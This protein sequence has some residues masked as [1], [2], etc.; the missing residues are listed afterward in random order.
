MAGDWIPMRLDLYED[1]AV[2]FM[3]GELNVREEVVVGYLHRVWSWASRQCHAGRVTNVTLMS[4]GR[5]TNVT[6]FPELMRDAGWLT[7]GIDGDGRRF[8]EFPNWENWLGQSAKKR[9][10]DA[11]RQQKR[12]SPNAV[13]PVTQMSRSKRDKNVTTVQESTGE[14]NIDTPVVPKGTLK[15]PSS[16]KS[17]PYSE[18]FEEFWNAY[19][20]GGRTGKLATF[21][22]YQKSLQMAT[23]EQLLKG[24]EMYAGCKKV[25]EGF[26]RNSATWLNQGCWEDTSEKAGQSASRIATEDDLRN[27]TP[28]G[29]FE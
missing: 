21:K 29:M 15:K 14:K 9:I 26:V 10:L 4:L 18:Q 22:A 28:N 16:V 20:T 8:V 1:P 17:S 2:V 5:V 27:Y 24:V 19:P 7:E 23:H 6:G 11:K 12:R 3:A 25:S 13:E